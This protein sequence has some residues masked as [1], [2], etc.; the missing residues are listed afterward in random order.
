MLEQLRSA[1]RHEPQ[2]RDDEL[3][4]TNDIV[5]LVIRFGRYG[6]RRI[7]ALL[8]QAGWE[9]NQKRVERISGGGRG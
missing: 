5:G 2:A 6:Y 7:T 8:R 1:Q 9:V 4:L 3:A